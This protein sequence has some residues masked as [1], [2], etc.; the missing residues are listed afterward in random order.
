MLQINTGLKKGDGVTVVLDNMNEIVG[1]FVSEDENSLVL[2]CVR[3]IV[4]QANAQGGVGISLHP[5]SYSSEDAQ[6]CEMTFSKEKI[7]THL[8][9]M[10]S[11]DKTLRQ[12]DTGI[13]GAG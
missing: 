4:P 7:I 12:D 5:I 13:V 8:K 2:S 1:R 6:K 9:A 10:D 3:M 11:I